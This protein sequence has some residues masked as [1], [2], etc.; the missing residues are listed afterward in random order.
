[1]NEPKWRVWLDN[2]RANSKDALFICGG[3]PDNSGG[4][5][6]ASCNTR[7]QAEQLQ[8]EALKFG[9]TFVVIQTWKEF[10]DCPVD[11][12]TIQ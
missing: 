3:N 4:G 7:R 10:L 1:M 11:G 9:F 6:I 8:V 12:G 2:Q 5:I